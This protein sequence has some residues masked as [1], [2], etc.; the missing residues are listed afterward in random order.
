MADANSVLNILQFVTILQFIFIAISPTTFPS[1]KMGSRDVLFRSV[2]SML[3][4]STHNMP[5]IEK[6]YC[7]DIA[8]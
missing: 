1:P 8:S 2:R 4:A 6:V 3:T 5:I 7:D